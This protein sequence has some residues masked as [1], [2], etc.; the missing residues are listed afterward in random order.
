MQW[1]KKRIAIAAVGG[2]FV[3]GAIGSA[4]EDSPTTG[5]GA[6]NASAPQ[7][8]KTENR[9]VS[10]PA[11]TPT[12]TPAPSLSLTVPG[13][14]TVYRDRVT[15]AGRVTAY[16]GGTLSG[17]RVTVDGKTAPV[18]GGRWSKSVTVDSGSTDIEIEATKG[19]Y[20]GSAKTVTLTR[21]RSKAELAAAAD[22]RRQAVAARKATY[23][24]SAK[25]IPYNQ[26]DKNA[27]RFSGDRAVFRGQIMQIQEDSGSTVILLSVTDEGYGFWTD[28][29]WVDYEGTIKGA[30]DD[31]I[32]VYGE[33][34]GSKSYETQIGGETYVPQMTAE[35]VVE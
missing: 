12:E 14:R 17:V 25:S 19:A 20:E 13:D 24:A 16:G 31:V 28:N 1:T 7:A 8:G 34:E 32:T 18:R 4:S 29:V 26:L 3:I 23:I 30:E 9:P 11:A 10:A 33:I 6:G 21:Q 5:A 22:R 15:I 35:Y 2:L 27:D